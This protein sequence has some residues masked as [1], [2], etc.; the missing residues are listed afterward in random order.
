MAQDHQLDV[1]SIH[2]GL[3][4]VVIIPQ[5][6]RVEQDHCLAN[7][8]SAFGT[9]EQANELLRGLVSVVQVPQP[10]IS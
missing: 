9:E 6:Q 5:L 8:L 3:P 10:P 7:S 1:W 4:L 2:C